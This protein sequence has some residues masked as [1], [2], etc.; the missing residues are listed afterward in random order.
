[1][2]DQGL[3][4]RA[5]T[6][7][8]PSASFRRLSAR[9]VL[10][11]GLLAGVAAHAAHAMFGFGGHAVDRFFEDW[12]LN[13]LILATSAACLL[14]GLRVRAERLAW[15]VLGAAMLSWSGGF[16]YWTL[17]IVRDPTPPYPS[18]AD[19]L[20]LAYYPAAYVALVLI[21]RSRIREFQKSLWLDGLIGGLAVASFGAALVFGAVLS[22]TGGNAT[23]IAINLAYPLG[24]M[25]LVAFV[26]S[27][28]ALTGWRP[29]R[30]GLLLGI[31]FALNAVGDSLWVH[32]YATGTYSHGSLTETIWPVATGLIALAAWQPA[33]RAPAVAL[34]GPR[35][36]VVPVVSG[37][38]ALGVLI[39]MRFAPLNDVALTLA[40]ATL[41]AVLA[42][43]VFTLREHLRLVEFSRG[44]ANTDAL[45]GLG[46][47][48]KFMSDLQARLLL[49]SP[50][51][52][53]TLALFDLDGF[54]AYNDTFGHP[55][56]D[57][58][59]TR[60]GHRLQVAVANPGVAYRLGGDEFC[61]LATGA[62][63]AATIQGAVQ[64]L[65]ERGEAFAI[66]N[67][68]G[69]VV[70]DD[71]GCKPEDA[72]RIAD[73]RMYECK[74]GGR[75][76]AGNQSKA[77]LVRALSERHPDLVSHNADVSRMAE[78]VA[79]QLNVP[80]DQLA[81]MHHAAELHDIGKVGIPDAILSKPGP[82]DPDE[83]AFIRRHTITGERI[84]AGAP[85]LAEVGRLVR[86]CHERWYGA[87]YPDELA[88][89]EIPMGSRIIAV[90]DAFDAILSERS[91]QSA[92]SASAAMAELRS[93]S[94]SQFAPAVV[95]AFCAAMADDA[96]P[97]GTGQL[98]SEAIPS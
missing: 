33:H 2:V 25:V 43:L 98:V 55:A 26:V 50:A 90:C 20:W 52:P 78:L 45:T 64:A 61:V 12:L 27:M 69:A 53:M 38:V 30:A 94:G 77:V 47:R 39:S 4:Y 15:L 79:R 75:Q 88:G 28:F 83:W 70:L 86:S 40:S 57:A 65:T 56:G 49:A 6:K 34:S 48:R 72:L 92:R 97:A 62:E 74:N 60:L 85:A 87:G 36:L 76:S 35:I 13:A 9:R 10:A 37:I 18:P 44:E 81:P 42:R 68:Y 95:D 96:S 73:Q 58:L 63:S 19:A 71:Q 66:S 1:M 11:F 31:G 51:H 93:C 89:E 5:D 80:E 22:N 3:R 91:Y 14:R 23:Q 84:V 24:D 41:L 67:S 32:S 29:G 46:N 82:L 54:K 7:G 59:L 8:M 16:V 21:I 17:F